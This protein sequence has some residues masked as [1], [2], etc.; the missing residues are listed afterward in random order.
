MKGAVITDIHFG[1]RGDSK[2]FLDNLTQ[3][4]EKTFFP[5][6]IENKVEF[7]LILGDTWENRKTLNINTFHQ[8]RK[9]FFDRLAELN[10]KT[11]MIYG[12]HDVFYKNT[13]EVNSIDF[14]ASMYPNIHVVKNHEIIEFDGLP[15]AFISWVNNSNLVESLDFIRTAPASILCGHFEIKTFEMI[16]GHVCNEG[17][18]KSIFDRYDMVW[19]GHFHVMSTDGRIEYLSNTNQSNWSDYGLKKGFRI[20]DT[21]TQELT[22][23]ENPFEVYSKVVY[24]DEISLLDF[25]YEQYRGKILRVYLQSFGVLN[26]Q[27]FNLFTERLQQVAHSLEVFEID[28]T[29]FDS[30]TENLSEDGTDIKV[31]IEQYILDV[32]KNELIDK[33]RLRSDFMDLYNTALTEHESE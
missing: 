32:V 17:F 19:S 21:K 29:V 2:Y 1:A 3:F 18:D 13:N 12:N 26:Q 24:T 4:L 6:I 30:E 31:L 10:L 28:E 33:D 7:V 9:V 20:F 27:K 5:S 23:I 15:I 14:L 16:K 11:I 25:N 8:A 22:L